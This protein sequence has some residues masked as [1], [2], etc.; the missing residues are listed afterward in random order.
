MRPGRENEEDPLTEL[1]KYDL[2][3][4]GTS[5]LDTLAFNG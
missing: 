5:L 2:H 4:F 3:L 1:L